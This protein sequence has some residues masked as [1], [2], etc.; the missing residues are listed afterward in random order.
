MGVE[1]NEI[2][3]YTEI[4]GSVLAVIIA[5]VCGAVVFYRNRLPNPSGIAIGHF[6][7]V[8]LV[9]CL[10]A[11]DWS[12]GYVLRKDGRQTLVMQGVAIAIIFATHFAALAKYV[13]AAH[14]DAVIVGVLGTCAGALYAITDWVYYPYCWWS[15]GCAVGLAGAASVLAFRKS[16]VSNYRTW[17][18]FA[19]STVLFNFGW[20]LAQAGSWSM[21]EV[22]DHSPNKTTSLIAYGVFFA[23]LAAYDIGAIFVY[24]STASVSKKQRVKTAA[25]QQ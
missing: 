14:H 1:A 7:L 12:W 5:A 2:I 24:D 10:C 8:G 15:W 16:R 13:H 18:L 17:I 20:P 4:G 9:A 22:F 11:V 21:L 6:V 19:C 23:C 25:E 3:A